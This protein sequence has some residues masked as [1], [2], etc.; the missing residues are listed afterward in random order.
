MGKD[1]DQGKVALELS[2]EGRV[3]TWKRTMSKV[4]GVDDAEF[5]SKRHHGKELKIGNKHRAVSAIRRMI[6]EYLLEIGQCT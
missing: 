5:S 3:E 4:K 2:S 6:K 1:E